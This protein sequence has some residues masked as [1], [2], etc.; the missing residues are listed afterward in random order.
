MIVEL[1][2]RQPRSL[3]GAFQKAI[4]PQEPS[5]LSLS[6]RAVAALG[7]YRARMAALSGAPERSWTLTGS[8][9]GPLPAFEALAAEVEAAVAALGTARAGGGSAERAA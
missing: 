2:R 1:G 5:D 3:M 9:A 7:E 4:V 6:E 8:A